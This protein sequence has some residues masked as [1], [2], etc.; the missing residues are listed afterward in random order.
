MFKKILII[1]VVMLAMLSTAESKENITLKKLKNGVSV[2]IKERKDT[3]AVAVQVWFGVGSIYENDKERG[4]SHFLEHMLFNGTKYTKPGEIEFEVEKKGGSINAATSFDFTYYHIEI[5]DMFWKD[6]LRYLYY[7][8]TQPSLS[9]E[10]VAKEKPIVLEELNRHLDNPKNYLWDTYYKL[11]YKKTNYK[12]PV[13]GY[14]ETIEN[15][16]PELVRDYFYSHY[17][18]S[19]TTV[20]V[21]GNV[22]TDEVLKEIENTFGTVKGK[23]YKPPKVEL[24]DPQTEVRREDIYKP[25]ITR[26][27]VAIGWQAPS[28]R[29]KKATAL[30]VLEEILFNGK[31]SV[32]Y[33]EL[34]EKGYVQSIYGGYM[35]HVGTSQF[36]I[37][38]VTEPEKVEDAKKRIFEI[39]KQYQ[40]NGIPK[41]VVENA[42]KRIINREVF[43]REEVDNDAES[44]GYAVTVTG[45]IKY[46]L[47][48]IERIKKVK[49]EDIENYLKTLKDNNYTEVRLLPEKK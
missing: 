16:T 45:D 32:M 7:M 31:S 11:A 41:E 28:I 3:Q 48:F 19:N 49:K 39:I 20:V 33:Q 21:V 27:Y 47:N 46:D 34:K 5:G 42:K 15:Y 14:R 35:A 29:D 26:A 17:T 36:L 23:Y 4:L 44:A 38:F 24:E 2:I 40:E 9:D 13:I 12:H 25:Q 6:A 10:M 30:N 8:T 1:G 43:A 22:K 37:Y 18:P